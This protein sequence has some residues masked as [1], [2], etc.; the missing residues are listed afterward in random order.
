MSRNDNP[1]EHILYEI[2]MYLYTYAFMSDDQF[3]LNMATDSHAMH[4]RNLCVFFGKEKRKEHSFNDDRKSWHVS[5]YLDSIE[6]IRLINDDDLS[7]RIWDCTSWATGHL[8]GKRLNDGFKEN[9][10]QCYQDAFPVLLDA[11]KDFL[12]IDAEVVKSD[13]KDQWENGQIQDVVCCINGL[14]EWKRCE[15]SCASTRLTGAIGITSYVSAP[16]IGSVIGSASYVVG[17]SC[18]ASGIAT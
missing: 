12:A 8:L 10:V 13:Y 2:E 11:I 16:T 14:I 17:A 4:L 5:D 18:I 7:R 1:F 9:T 3:A 6:G 15:P